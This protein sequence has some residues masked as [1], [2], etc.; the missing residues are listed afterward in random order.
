[1]DIQ[2]KKLS[3]IQKIMQVETIV[4]LDKMDQLIDEELIV[5][6]STA[7]EP[8]TQHAYNARLLAAEAAISKGE[9]L[10]QE[11]IKSEVKSW[12]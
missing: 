9:F 6:Y 2:T 11:E 12:L 5:A 8:L 4:L 3:L 10:T 1:M 7:N